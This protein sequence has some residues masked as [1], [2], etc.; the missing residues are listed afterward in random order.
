M[1]SGQPVSSAPTTPRAPA[2]E[3]SAWV[4]VA[5]VLAIVYVAA[6]FWSALAGSP[7]VWVDTRSYRL[8]ANNSFL[9]ADLWFGSRPPLMPVIYK[10]AGTNNDVFRVIQVGISCAAWLLLAFVVAR[11]ASTGWRRATAFALVLVF[12]CS[13]PIIQW[14]RSV[15]SESLA[16]SMMVILVACAILLAERVTWPRAIATSAAFIAFTSVRDTDLVVTA[17][18]GVA[19]LVICV[20]ALARKHAQGLA[21]VVLVAVVA[22][23]VAIGTSAVQLVK[24]DAE[25]MRNVLSA[26]I[27]PHADRLDWFADH[28]MPD[29]PALRSLAAAHRLDPHGALATSAKTQ[30]YRE[31][32]DGHTAARVYREWLVTHPG[33]FLTA[34]FD[35]VGASLPISHYRAPGFRTLLGPVSRVFFAPAWWL[36]LWALIVLV[37][38]TYWR[39]WSAPVWQVAIV[40][41]VL[42]LPHAL[43]AWHGDAVEMERHLFLA[44]TQV[45]LAV[46]LATC[47]LVSIPGRSPARSR[48]PQTQETGVTEED[49]QLIKRG[50]E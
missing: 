41:G 10:L 4:W 35:N 3:R 14:D 49:P 2:T 8:V 16:I 32:I 50:V 40:V 37:W 47:A 5:P 21:P 48:S 6:R 46:V 42:A 33:Y 27:L 34:P 36:T 39:R 23:G 11:Y 25:P 9:S 12:S 26:R 24:R 20:I 15:L 13:T 17:I 44:A 31:W 19:L 43:A 18:V 22:I 1:N 30:S 45:R 7:S 38:G 28:G 29:A